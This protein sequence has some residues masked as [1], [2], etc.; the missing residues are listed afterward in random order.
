MGEGVRFCT[1]RWAGERGGR[2]GKWSRC[3][4]RSKI[5]GGLFCGR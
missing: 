5:G 1:R 2:V 4:P 3:S